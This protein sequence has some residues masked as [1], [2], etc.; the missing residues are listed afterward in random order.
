MDVAAFSQLTASV[1]KAHDHYLDTRGMMGRLHRT[2]QFPYDKKLRKKKKFKKGFKLEDP[3]L[4]RAALDKAMTEKQRDQGS[5]AQR[6]NFVTEVQMDQ[7]CR[8]KKLRVRVW[9]Y[10]YRY[11][12]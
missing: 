10:H 2:H 9:N 12:H 4:T 3:V 11:K 1:K 7:L 5:A 8:G 6:L